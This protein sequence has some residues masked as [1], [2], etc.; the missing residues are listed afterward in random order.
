LYEIAAGGRSPID[1]FTGQK[2]AGEFPEH[3]SAIQFAPADS[4][5]E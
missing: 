3:Q 5:R 2:N 1:H 4:A